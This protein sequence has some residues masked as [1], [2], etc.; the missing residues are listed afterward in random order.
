VVTVYALEPDEE[1]AETLAREV[2]AGDVDVVTLTSGSAARAVARGMQKSGLSTGEVQRHT[3]VV[4]LGPVTASAASEMGI[5]V[6]AIAPSATF[7]SLV[8][9]VIGFR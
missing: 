7:G 4:A 3:R 2:R 6:D 8:E 1:V 5:R 9:T